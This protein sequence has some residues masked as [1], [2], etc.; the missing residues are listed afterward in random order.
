MLFKQDSSSPT[1]DL[2]FHYRGARG[3]GKK[4]KQTKQPFKFP[5]KTG[6]VILSVPSGEQPQGG[7]GRQR[8]EDVCPPELHH[9]RQHG[10]VASILGRHSSKA[11]SVWEPCTARAHRESH[12]FWTVGLRKWKTLGSG[13][14]ESRAQWGHSTPLAM[15]RSFT[16]G[17]QRA[18]EAPFWLPV[19]LWCHNLQGLFCPES[20]W[21]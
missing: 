1:K 8:T 4:N 3:R 7:G 13:A 21:P 6:H 18:Y 14:V 5:I 19:P 2:I 10:A 11:P 12:C 20:T 17:W 9:H 15:T 16:L